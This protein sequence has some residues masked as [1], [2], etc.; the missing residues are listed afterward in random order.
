MSIFVYS[1]ICIYLKME[2]LTS[3]IISTFSFVPIT[4]GSGV[5]TGAGVGLGVGCNVER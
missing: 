2:T 1:A 4:V 3:G 5:D